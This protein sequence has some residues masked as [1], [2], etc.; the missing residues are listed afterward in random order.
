MDTTNQT[1]KPSAT[2]T[3]KSAHTPGPW[4][5]NTRFEVDRGDV[6]QIIQDSDS[7]PG[8]EQWICDVGMQHLEDCKANA[9]LI[10]AAPEL[11]AALKHLTAEIHLGALNIR[12]DF[13]LINAHASAT[14]AIAKA[15][16]N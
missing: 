15:E 16:G 11:L 14:R 9:R 6:A 12:K 3:D 13:S 10:A 8:E 1:E 2:T 4:K 5:I 7:I